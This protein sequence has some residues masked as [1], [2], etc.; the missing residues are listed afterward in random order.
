MFW[1]PL[2]IRS[3]RQR[4]E[5]HKYDEGHGPF[6]KEG[7]DEYEGLN[8]VVFGREIWKRTERSNSTSGKEDVR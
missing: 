1:R 6:E 3:G 5:E 4:T 8:R 2:V 7:I